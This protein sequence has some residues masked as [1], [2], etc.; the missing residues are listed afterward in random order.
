MPNERRVGNIYVLG[1]KL[2]SGS[3]G[4]IYLAVNEQTGVEYAVKLENA[5]TR[6]PQ[7]LYEAKLLRHL[8]GA[9]GIANV[10]YSGIEGEFNVMVMD[11][12]GPSLE[13]LYNFCGRKLSLRSVLNIADQMLERIEYLHE[14]HFIHRDIKPDNFLIGSGSRHTILYLIDYGLAK[15]FRDPRTLQ[16][17]PY[18]DNKNLT[19]TARYASI[20]AHLGIEQS[21]RD[22]L[23]SIGYVL[24]Y[25][26]N[27]SLPWQGL[28]ANTKHEKYQRIM[29]KK[30][31]TPI[32]SLCK[33]LPSQFASYIAY[34]RLLRF[35][36]KPDYSELRHKFRELYIR[37]SQLAAR[38]ST[39]D[40]LAS[41]KVFDWESV[42][43]ASTSAAFSNSNNQLM[44]PSQFLLPTVYYQQQQQHRQTAPAERNFA[45]EEIENNCYNM[46]GEIN[47]NHPLPVSSILD[48]HATQGRQ[49]SP[50]LRLVANMISC[51]N[52][53]DTATTTQGKHGH[54]FISEQQ[55]QEQVKQPQP[56]LRHTASSSSVNSI[57]KR[58]NNIQRRSNSGC[59][60][61]GNVF[62]RLCYSNSRNYSADKG[63]K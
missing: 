37:E 18:K 32:E 27:G 50:E 53:G 9:P 26:L 60:I 21:R 61:V 33:G 16:H 8:H 56:T 46:D 35:D 42:V 41:Q 30:I 55:L 43:T 45:K 38:N 11:L 51:N 39:I 7:L 24:I 22:D 63:K 1:K 44:V 59:N 49:S 13:D 40:S 57:L 12:L 47:N 17:I 36:D 58:K 3:F 31:S 20:N 15:R 2:G 48:N 19:G 54:T 10:Y 25:L 34:V 62:G 14:R 29:E 28:K 6:H 23:E 5:R 52:L 4:D